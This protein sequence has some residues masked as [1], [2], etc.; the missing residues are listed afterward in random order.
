MFSTISSI[1]PFV[2]SICFF[3]VVEFAPVVGVTLDPLGEL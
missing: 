3:V 1:P 2:S